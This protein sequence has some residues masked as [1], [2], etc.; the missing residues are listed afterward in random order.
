MVK[1]RILIVEDDP[2]VAADI[3]SLILEKKDY[4]VSGVAHDASSAL[5]ILANRIVDLILLDINLGSGPTG[6]DIAKVINEKHELPFIFLTAFSDEHTLAAASE[7]G[8][9]GYLVKPFNDRGLL[10]TIAVALRNAQNKPKE[11]LIT[12]TFP[13]LTG[14]E[15]KILEFVLSGFSNKKISDKINISVNTVKFHLKNIYVKCQ[16]NS[17]QELLAIALKKI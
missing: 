1:P 16:V 6:I 2:I 13:M 5:D 15:I 17:K 14:Q 12:S 4:L 3:E 9:S 10:T 8:P 11:E 7:L